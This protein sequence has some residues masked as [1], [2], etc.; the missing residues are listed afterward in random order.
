M[1]QRS[2]RLT[3]SGDLN[4]LLRLG[5]RARPRLALLVAVACLVQ[6]STGLVF[7]AWLT[8]LINTARTGGDLHIFALTVAAG[9][10]I[11]LTVGAFIGGWRLRIRIR[12]EI[13]AL[14]D[15][16][17]IHEFSRIPTLDLHSDPE[18]LNRL[19]TLQRQRTYLSGGFEALWT[20]LGQALQVL[21]T[22]IILGAIHAPL[23]A[24]PLAAI[25]ALFAA[26]FGA[27]HTAEGRTRAGPD[28]RQARHH[29]E[30]ATAAAG[31]REMRVFG[32]YP[33]ARRRHADT[34]SRA[35]A[36]MQ[37]ADRTATGL[38]IAAWS[39]FAAAFGA[40]ALLVL[41]QAASG[42]VSPGAAAAAIVLASQ[43]GGQVQSLLTFWNNVMGAAQLARIYR[44]LVLKAADTQR[45]PGLPQHVPQTLRSGLRLDG[46]SFTYPGAKEPSLKRTDVLLPAGSV[47]A[48]VGENGAGKSTLVKVLLGLLRPDAGRVLADGVDIEAFGDQAWR[49]RLAGSFQDFVRFEFDLQRVVGIGDL[50]LVDQRGAIEEALR[51]AGS[52]ELPQQFDHGLSTPLG[53]SLLGARPSGGQWQQL[54]I[55][56]GEM[57]R[58]PLLRVLD[59]PTASLD[60]RREEAL[61][62]Q[63]TALTRASPAGGV[64]V[65]VTHRFTTARSADLIVVMDHGEIVEQGTHETLLASGGLYAQLYAIQAGQ[66]EQPARRTATANGAV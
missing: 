3:L 56:R 4:A 8:V 15:S 28:L 32:L 2:G 30:A 39:L 31:A 9:A 51:R 45:P 5:F 36:I 59:E 29:S 47:I 57:R 33:L 34:W 14:L 46:L 37:T 12:E 6:Q 23:A 54:A 63:L 19:E 25:P 61:F 17:L 24:L 41:R 50:A 20:L 35:G 22:A 16:T 62:E 21:V 48:L 66:F 1:T 52:A 43:L 42:Q 64:T 11:G 13:D 60:A 55:A 65:L 18:T 58:T 49:A 44:G 27:R 26:H 38:A 7:A 10:S 53:E 40:T